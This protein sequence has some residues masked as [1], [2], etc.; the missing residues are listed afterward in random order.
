M[1]RSIWAE[2]LAQD[3]RYSARVLIKSPGFAAIVL[4]TL[5]LGIGANTTV[6][7]VVN[8]VL[9]KPLPFS[10]P[11]R[12]YML[13][14]KT[15]T[16]QTYSVSYP[17]FLDWQRG[18][19]TFSSMAAFR[20]DNFVLMGEGRPERLHAA[21]ISAGLLS[22]LGVHPIIGREFRAEE[23]QL[24]A[25]GVA[26]ISERLWGEK[27]GANPNVLGRSLELSGAAY[28]IVGVVPESLQTLKFRMGPA[29]VYIPVGQWRDTS[30]RDRKVTT[31]MYVVGR[32]RAGKTEAAAGAELS[33]LAANLTSVYPDTNR[34]VGINIV[35]LKKVVAAGLETMLFVLL[36]AVCFVWLIACANVAN[37]LLARS[38]GRIRE[39]ATRTALGASPKRVIVQLLTESMLL[40][41]IGSG[42]GLLLALAGTRYALR[43]A[44]AGIPRTE[45]IGIDGR[46]LAF[47]FA[48]SVV[49]GILFGVAPIL[50]I[51]RLNLSES[52][53]EG[54]R[55][56]SGLR[57]RAQGIFVITEVALALML[58]VG[59]GLM[60]RSLVKLWGVHPGFDAHNVLV[61]DITPS[62]ATAVDA[63]KIRT[64]FRQL[65]E[66]LETLPGIEAASMILD[67]LPL[68]GMAD[69]VPFNIE[70]RPLPS[71]PNDKTSAIW[72]FV[73]PDYFR[74]MGIQLKRGRTFRVTDDKKAPQVALI[75]EVFARSLFPNEDPIGKRITISF[76][77]ASEIIG[78]VAHVNHWN[79]GTDPAAFVN[80]QMYL[81]YAQLADKYLPLG[82]NG[83]ATVVVRTQT[84]PLSFVGA[85][86]DL[87]AKLDGVEAMYDVRTMN[88]IVDTWLATR[89]FAMILLGVF[90]MLALLLSSIGIY[91]VI[92]YIVG[93]RKHEIG[94]RMALGAQPEDILRLVLAHGGKLAF[95]GIVLGTTAAV[96]LTRLMSG[97]L[98]GVSAI[99]PVTFAGVAIL[100]VLVSLAA[101]CV[102]ARRAM[103]VDPL[104]FLRIE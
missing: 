61:F 92:S 5:A 24:G 46:V 48:I 62:P 99:D 30:F 94:I 49:A 90:A 34:D 36:L 67:P 40:A 6:F 4:V 39:F 76:T 85:V 69:A 63:Q 47:T 32:L 101:C 28:N 79:L 84:E 52:L 104:T 64:S 3:L 65:T 68:T 83:G 78:V 58:L 100:L 71:N 91:G 2:Q 38:T 18:N 54:G 53:K 29:D 97:L 10:E 74:T 56:S 19:E 75:D 102:P 45:T 59:A 89:R 44:P 86:Q 96:L 8:G 87:A 57:H 27:F 77:G 43:L 80:R 50:K 15:P 26:L 16:S 7:S 51:L 95:M 103:R 17:N 88:Q 93:Q 14:E 33:Q 42:I 98:Y 23:D 13:Y 35:P 66:R 1:S 21:M 31:G 55:G 72:Y 12:L 11:D 82:V 73:S 70:G 22:T 81:P 60:I 20:K 25:G 41:F 9:F 37:L